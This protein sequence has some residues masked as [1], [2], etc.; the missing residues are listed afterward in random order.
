MATPTLPR[1]H[2]RLTTL[3][4][5][6][7][8]RHLL[9]STALAFAGLAATPT[10]AQTERLIGEIFCGG[11]NFAPRGTMLLQGQILPI[12]QYSALYSLLGTTFGGNGQTTFAL[13]DMRGRVLVG[14][15]QG[16]GLSYYDLGEVGG[17]EA[18]TLHQG[19]M[20]AHNHQVSSVGSTSVANSDS[21]ANR[22]PA[23]KPRSPQYADATNTVSMGTTVTSVAGSSMPFSVQQPYLT[24][25]CVIVVDGIFPSRND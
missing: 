10:H 16:P 2:R 24:I 3:T 21:P 20:P 22:V 1:L 14:W 5:K 12:A 13:P 8:Q 11:W 18:V 6:S 4:M 15:G 9:A 25:N 19:N 17:T 7:L 23:V